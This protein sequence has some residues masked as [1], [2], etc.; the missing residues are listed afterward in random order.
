MAKEKQ[1]LT[2]VQKILWRAKTRQK[3]LTAK[4]ETATTDYHN[5]ANMLRAQLQEQQAI[6]DALEK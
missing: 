3:N 5:I 2:A 4:L 6:I 1:K